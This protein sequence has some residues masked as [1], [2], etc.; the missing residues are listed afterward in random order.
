MWDEIIHQFP[1]FT[2]AAAEVWNG[3]VIYLPLYWAYDY[4]STLELKLM[5]GSKRTPANL[6]LVCS[7]SLCFNVMS[8]FKPPLQQSWKGGILVS[9]CPSVHMS[10]CPSVDRIVSTLY[11]QQYSSDLFHI[12]TSYQATSEGVSCVMPVSQF[13]DLKFWRIFLNL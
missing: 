4:L 8:Y 3:L 5:H 12:C 7:V 1:N 11:L 13:K 2:G 6:P 10:V 9:P